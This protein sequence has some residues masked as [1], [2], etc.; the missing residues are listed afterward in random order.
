ML[1]EDYLLNDYKKTM[2]KTYIQ[3]TATVIRF[4]A[5]SAVATMMVGSKGSGESIN[6]GDDWSNER[7][8]DDESF[9]WSADED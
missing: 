4:D 2:K 7:Q 9:D 3:P 5:E 1:N 6:Q 8:W